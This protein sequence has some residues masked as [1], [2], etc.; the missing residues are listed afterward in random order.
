MTAGYRKF[1]V[2]DFE[3]TTHDKTYGRPRA[4]FPEIIEVGAVLL[5]PPSFEPEYKF[6][7]FVKPAFFPKLSE[8]CKNITM[9]TQKDVDGGITYQAMLDELAA[10]YIPGE[11]YLAAWG[12]ADWEVLAGACSRYKIVCPFKAAD[13]VDLAVEYRQFYHHERR[14]SLKHALEERKLEGEGLHH[15]AMDDTINAARVM[16]E[17]IAAGWLPGAKEKLAIG[18]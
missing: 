9:I 1:L 16:Y 12:D 2:V 5:T 6:Q 14:V 18:G 8:A 4:F 11:T 7:S 13:Y 10:H 3:F 17:M 15:C